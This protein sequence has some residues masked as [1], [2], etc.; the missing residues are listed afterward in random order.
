VCNPQRISAY[1]AFGATLKSAEFM[2]L[3]RTSRP[4]ASVDYGLRL[5]RNRLL[6]ERRRADEA[7]SPF[8]PPAGRRKPTQTRRKELLSIR[9][10]LQ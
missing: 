1:A 8:R 10:Q 3:Q 7:R 2:R 9:K 4:P 6:I 5:I